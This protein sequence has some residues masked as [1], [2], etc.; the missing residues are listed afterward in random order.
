MQLTASVCNSGNA[1]EN[2][3]QTETYRLYG[4]RY[5]TLL[6]RKFLLCL[7]AQRL[8]FLI[9]TNKRRL[10]GGRGDLGWD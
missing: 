2:A 10:M 7:S 5:T 1:S 9:N 8:S 3:A 6:C 4:I